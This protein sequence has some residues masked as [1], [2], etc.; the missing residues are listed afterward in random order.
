M[1]RIYIAEGKNLKGE[2]AYP[3]IV[4]IAKGY[5]AE[6]GI[7]F[8]CD[9]EDLFEIKRTEKDKPYFVNLPIEFSVSHSEDMWMCIMSD[10]PCGIDIQVEKDTDVLKIAERFYRPN[11]VEYVRLFGSKGFFQIWT[12]REA[13]GKMTGQG[14]WGSIPELVNSDMT[15]LESIDNFFVSDIEVGDGIS[16]AFCANHPGPFPISVSNSTLFLV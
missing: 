12:R 9:K 8:D 3:L 1:N 2:N 11:E 5:A 13:Y 14:F 10:A 15:L 4:D 6:E 7:I 16:A